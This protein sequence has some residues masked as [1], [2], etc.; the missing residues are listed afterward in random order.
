[1]SFIVAG[2]A[3]LLALPPRPFSTIS[4]SGEKRGATSR[5]S[6]RGEHAPY[7]KEA[8]HGRNRKL[9]PEPK[10]ISLP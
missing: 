8:A 6:M 10:P 3:L 4:G 2:S 9:P 7:N 1:M 5:R